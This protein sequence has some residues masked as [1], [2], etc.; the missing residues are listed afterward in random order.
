MLRDTTGSPDL[1]RHAEPTSTDIATGEPVVEGT[2]T[3][4]RKPA[5]H[6]PQIGGV[7]AVKI[8]WPQETLR[9]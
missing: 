6:L 4:R 8:R 5:V 7:P 2:I 1:P 9:R 3:A